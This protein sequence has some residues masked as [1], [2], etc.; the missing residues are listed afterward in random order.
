MAQIAKSGIQRYF[1]DAVARFFQ[2]Q[3]LGFFDADH[4]Q[5]SFERG[6]QRLLE[7]KRQMRG[8]EERLLGQ[9]SQRD[10]VIEI[11]GNIG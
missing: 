11:P 3:L 6:P 4:G 5:H 8:T 1:R 2:E 7:Q 9:L 10:V